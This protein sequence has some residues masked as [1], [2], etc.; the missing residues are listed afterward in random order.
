M[1]VYVYVCIYVYIR[2]DFEAGLGSKMDSSEY[3]YCL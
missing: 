2:A 3:T 1:C